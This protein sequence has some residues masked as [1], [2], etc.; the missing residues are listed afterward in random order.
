MEFKKKAKTN[1]GKNSPCANFSASPPVFFSFRKRHIS[2]EKTDDTA[3]LTQDGQG[4]S[5]ARQTTD[6][7]A[8]GQNSTLGWRTSCVLDGRGNGEDVI[9]RLDKRQQTKGQ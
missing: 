5:I 6:G 3:R 7:T 1:S 2:T 9:V 4:T 8:Y